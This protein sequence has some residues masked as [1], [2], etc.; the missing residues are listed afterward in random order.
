MTPHSGYQFASAPVG[1]V[2]AL[3]TAWAFD[4]EDLTAPRVV[5]AQARE[6]KRVRVSFPPKFQ[7]R[8]REQAAEFETLV[9]ASSR[10][11]KR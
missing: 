8:L 10:K 2:F 3:D 11:G 9:R 7:R 5:A 4:C 1:G 6:L